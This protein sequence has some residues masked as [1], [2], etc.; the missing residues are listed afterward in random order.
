MNH[1]GLPTSFTLL[2]LSFSTIPTT[3]RLILAN[4]TLADAK[5]L[6]LNIFGA[7][8]A[9]GSA[10]TQTP[11]GAIVN[12]LF[13]PGEA[14]LAVDAER[15]ADSGRSR[16]AADLHHQGHQ[17]RTGRGHRSDLEPRRSCWSHGCDR[18]RDARHLRL[19][20][21][22]W[23]CALGTIPAGGEAVAT[24][25]FVPAGAGVLVTT[26]S[27]T[28]AQADSVT[29]NNS[30]V[31][32]ATIVPAGAGVNLSIAKTDSLESVS[33]GGSFNY[34]I[35]VTNAGTTVATGV[36][37]ID[38][39]PTGIT[40]LAPTS[41]Q[42]TCSIAAGQVQCSVGTLNPGQI[43][44]ITLPTTAGA[45]GLVT[46]TA[47]VTSNEVDLT[48]LNNLASQQTMIVAT[49]P[50]ISS[51]DPVAAELGGDTATLLVSRP[52][53]DPATAPLD[54]QL[55]ISGTAVNGV[56]YVLSSPALIDNGTVFFAVRI[57]AGQ[58]SVEVTLTA[59]PDE[60]SEGVETATFTLGAA[61]PVT[62]VIVD[63]PALRTWVTDADGFWDVPANW[64]GGVVP[65]PG[66]TVVIDRPVDI[67]VT[68]RTATTIA[69]LVS[70]ER[71]TITGGTLRP[72]GRWCSTVV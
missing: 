64:S 45:P 33:P 69:S 30:H 48:P 22:A 53:G 47:F 67:T 60:L 44:T 31:L 10:D 29:I 65:Q 56:D 66:D 36:H 34:S 35:V 14:N 19:V 7:V 15:V 32:A 21:G 55:S 9:D 5:Q 59:P 40:I 1:P 54:L 58:A 27:V 42:G 52:S 43:V 71:L 46:N 39:I 25:T 11:G 49:E 18:D 50:L 2:G 62:V 3:G 13:N 57:P 17:R 28:A 72:T 51:T 38:P 23:S 8:P 70:Q 68:L 41:T 24:V 20:A 63:T 4:D 16:H 12:W 61:E 6:V 26:A 37:V